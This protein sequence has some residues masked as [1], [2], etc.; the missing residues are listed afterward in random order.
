[1][2]KKFAYYAGIMLMLLATYYAPNYA[3]IIGAGLAG[4]IKLLQNLDIH[5]ASALDQIS[6]RVLKETA[7]PTAP[8]LKTIFAYLMDTGTVPGDWKNANVTPVCKNGDRTKPS[9]YRPI[10][11][12]NIVSKIFE[13]IHT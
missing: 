4:I 13:H 7:E 1:M 2:H 10:S 5:K 6:S 8:I 11:L 12:T 9:N 3:G